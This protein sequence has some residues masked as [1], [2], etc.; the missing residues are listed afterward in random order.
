MKL[1]LT[2]RYRLLFYFVILLVFVALAFTVYMYRQNR[3]YS[4]STLQSEL[5]NYSADLYEQISKGT[6]PQDITPAE[7]MQFSLLD[8]LGKVLYD[9]MEE[10]ESFTA[11]Q[12]NFYEVVTALAVG[13]GSTLRTSPVD[14][15]IEYLYYARRF[16]DKIV[17][18]YVKFS[19][20]KPAQIETDNKYFLIIGALLLALIVTAIF[21][22]NKLVKPLKSYSELTDA[23]KNNHD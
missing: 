13:E 16:G 3:S 17:K 21:I 8:T 19:T 15:N 10:K 5:K 2:Y 14:D 9:S 7:K 4:L 6:K 11:D 18:T 1:R 20:L 22:T 23:I 12:S